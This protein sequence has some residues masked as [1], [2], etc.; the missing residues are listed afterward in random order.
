[1][2]ESNHFLIVFLP[3]IIVSAMRNIKSAYKVKRNWEGDACVPQDYTWEGV[4]CSYNGTSMP[5]VIAL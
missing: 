2:P 3:I 1:M 4:D 5:R